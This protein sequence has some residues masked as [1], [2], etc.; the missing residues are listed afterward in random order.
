MSVYLDKDTFDASNPNGFITVTGGDLYRNIQH[1]PTTKLQV[2]KVNYLT[3]LPIVN[4]N[5]L[6]LNI[7]SWSIHQLANVPLHWYAMFC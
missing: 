4:G 2:L 1:K 5:D 6:S 3:K 7:T